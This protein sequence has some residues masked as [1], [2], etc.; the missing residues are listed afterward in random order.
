MVRCTESQDIW[1]WSHGPTSIWSSRSFWSN[2]CSGKATQS[3]VPRPTYRQL[4]KVS[5]PQGLDL[6][7]CSTPTQ[8]ICASWWS[9][10][11]SCGP[12]CAH[13]LLSC[14]WSPQERAWLC[15]LCT[16]SS[17]VNRL[18]DYKLLSLLF[19]R[20]KI[21]SS[22]SLSSVERC[23]SPFII[24]NTVFVLSSECR[25]IGTAVKKINA[26]LVKTST[27]SNWHTHKYFILNVMQLVCH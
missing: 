23:S 10:G 2:A 19:L 6:C 15:P 14:P 26:I 16:L 22:L 20:L 11:T 24:F 25:T 17:S 5:R 9:E 4:L 8:H 1:G 13:C 18:L 7:Q 21:L 3:N 12:V 27:S